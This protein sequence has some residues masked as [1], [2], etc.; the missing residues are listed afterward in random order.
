MARNT[1]LKTKKPPT[2]FAQNAQA[3]QAAMPMGVLHW[4]LI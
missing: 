2:S 3:G 1:G 4:T